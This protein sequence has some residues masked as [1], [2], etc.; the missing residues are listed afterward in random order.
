[1]GKAILEEIG[2]GWD[3]GLPGVVEPGKGFK[4]HH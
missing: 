1:M 3:S 2:A 4:G